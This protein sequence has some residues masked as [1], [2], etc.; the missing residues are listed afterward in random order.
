MTDFMYHE[1]FLPA[2]FAF[3]DWKSLERQSALS[4]TVLSPTRKQAGGEIIYKSMHV[5]NPLATPVRP[6]QAI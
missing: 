2:S 5:W 4:C 6:A 3:G 1:M